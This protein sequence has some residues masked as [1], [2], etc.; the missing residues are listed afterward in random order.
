[1]HSR[2]SIVP[3][4]DKEHDMKVAWKYIED[5]HEDFGVALFIVPVLLFAGAVTGV[6]FLLSWL[7]Q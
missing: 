6:G 2:K 7:M 4:Q 3:E 5:H 1:M